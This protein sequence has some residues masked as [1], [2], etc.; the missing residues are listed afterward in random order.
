MAIFNISA[1]DGHVSLVIRAPC[2]V[3]ARQAAVERSPAKETKLWRNPDLS[4]VKL[5]VHP[6]QYGYLVEG[7][8]GIIKRTNH[9]QA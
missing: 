9:E 6:E 2:V 7:R 1:R 4:E 8:R 5:I 3:C